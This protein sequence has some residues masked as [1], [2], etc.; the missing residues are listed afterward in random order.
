MPIQ[1]K[2]YCP[3]P[4]RAMHEP[5][6]GDVRFNRKPLRATVYQTESGGQTVEGEVRV[7]KNCGAVYVEAQG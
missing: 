5:V 7:C 6:K 1:I 4:A 2:N 3:F